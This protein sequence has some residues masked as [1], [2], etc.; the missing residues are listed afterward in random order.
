MAVEYADFL[1]EYYSANCWGCAGVD[2]QGD[3]AGGTG[4]GDEGAVGEVWGVDSEEW[5]FQ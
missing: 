3:D 4:G 2:G 5:D 1:F